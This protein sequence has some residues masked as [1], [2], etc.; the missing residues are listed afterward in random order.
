MSFK[1]QTQRT[2]SGT[3]VGE[4]ILTWI[5]AFLIDRWRTQFTIQISKH[6]AHYNNKDYIIPIQ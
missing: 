4:Y 5:D 6:T 3:F 1:T 2:I